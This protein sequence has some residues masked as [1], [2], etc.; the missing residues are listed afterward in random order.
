M[1]ILRTR[2]MILAAAA[3]AL[4]VAPPG[5]SDGLLANGGG[6]QW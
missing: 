1:G 4:G 6:L 3:L 5:V 2:F